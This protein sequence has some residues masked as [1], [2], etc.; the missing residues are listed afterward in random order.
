MQLIKS[1]SRPAPGAGVS[2][3]AAK[4]AANQGARM[5]AWRATALLAKVASSGLACIQL[6]LATT[7]PSALDR[8]GR[9]SLQLAR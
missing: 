5:R 2:L 1:V 4:A 7:P 8:E 9:Y 3:A 6:G